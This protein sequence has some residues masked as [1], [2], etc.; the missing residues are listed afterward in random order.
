[1]TVLDEVS[2]GSVVRVKHE[3]QLLAVIVRSDFCE[4]GITFFTDGEL[5]QQMGF[6]RH[7]AGKMIEP[8]LHN[9]ISRSINFTQEALFIRRGKLRVDFYADDQRYLSSHVLQTGDVV[10]LISGGH[11]FEVLE[12]IEMIEIK[13]GPYA[14]DRDKTRFAAVR[15][16]QR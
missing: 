7:P 12:E 11:G 6:M 8:H 2:A 5:S 9:H 10:L 3:E 15:S 16:E 4:P 14:G 13:Q 1:M